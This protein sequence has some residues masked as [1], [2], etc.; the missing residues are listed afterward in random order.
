[1]ESRNATLGAAIART[2]VAQRRPVRSMAPNQ[3][4]SMLQ[5]TAAMKMAAHSTQS[6]QTFVYIFRSAILSSSKLLASMPEDVR[7]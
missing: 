4:H 1:M 3:V 7:P 5:L 2:G 6:A